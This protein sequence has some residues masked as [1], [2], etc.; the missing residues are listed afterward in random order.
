ME[1]KK[2]PK[3][4]VSRRSMLF[5]QLGMVVMLFLAWQAIEWKSYDKSDNDYGQLN[6]GD[7]LEEEVPITQ[8]LTPPPPPPP[9][10]PAPEVIEVMEDEAEEEET[11][12]KSTETKQDAKI[13][14][15]KE[16]KEEVVEEEI[17][18]VPFAVIENVPIYPG[19]EN[20][21]GNDA[22]K[23]CMSTKISEFINKKFDTN[24]AS[25]LGLEGRQRIAVQFK[26]DKNGKVIDVR[27][28]APHP[29]LEKEAVSV[30]QSLPNMTP[31]KQRGKPVGVLY[32]LPIIFDIQ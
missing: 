13:V 2:N 20:E 5:F 24:L 27:A 30:V 21:K 12:I 17:A 9:P 10:P 6:V 7:E 15:V 25:D 28:R 19:C 4:D 16:I 3:A 32:S 1:P 31:G 11:I 14:E 26:I 18:D 8:Q 29:R 22:K 23:R